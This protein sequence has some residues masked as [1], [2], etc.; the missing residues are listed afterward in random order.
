MKVGDIV[1]IIKPHNGFNIYKGERAI[2]VYTS[3]DRY[4]L[5]IYKQLKETAWYYED[6]LK[7]IKEIEYI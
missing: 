7:L 2:I 5:Y 6:E 3:G 4:G 1:E